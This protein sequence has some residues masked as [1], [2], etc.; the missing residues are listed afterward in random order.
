MTLSNIFLA[1]VSILFAET[2]KF[3]KAFN[4][5]HRVQQQKISARSLE[6]PKS[7]L[8][9]NIPPVIPKDY[10]VIYFESKKNGGGLVLE[11]NYIPEDNSAIITFQDSKGNVWG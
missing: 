6:M 7:I 5:Y 3:I 8:V 2:D 10:I 11:N 1:Y 9:E 4:Q